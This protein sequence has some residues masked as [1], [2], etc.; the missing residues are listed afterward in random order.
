MAAQETP[1]SRIIPVSDYAWQEVQ[2]GVRMKQ[3]WADE[4]TGR[5]AVMSRIEPNA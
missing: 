2:P 5:R 4:Q 1:R 3:L